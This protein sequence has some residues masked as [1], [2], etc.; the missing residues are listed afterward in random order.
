[1]F[2]MARKQAQELARQYLSGHCTLIAWWTLRHAG[3]FEAIVK[4]Q[5]ENGEG[6]DPLVHATRTSMSPDVLRAL[7]DYLASVGLITMKKDGAH[8]SSEG[9]ALLEHE[10]AVLEL[11]RAYQLVLDMA[12]HLLA[13]LKTYAPAG[14]N[15]GAGAGVS[16]VRKSE[17]LA[18]SQAKRYAGEVYPAVGELVAKYKLAHLLDI[19]CGTGELLVHVATAHKRVVGVGI[20]S[21]GISV[22]KANAA[23]TAADL[24]KRLIAVTASPFDVC[25]DTQHTFDRIGVSRQL[26]KAINGILATNLFSE[27][28]ARP[29]EIART[30]TAVQKNF[31]TAT[32]ILIEPTASA[33]FDRN[34]YAPELTLV[35]SLARAVPWPVEQWRTALAQARY[36]LV[37]E[38]PLTTDGLTIFTCKPQT[39]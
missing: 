24:E 4:S 3:I 34:Y 37:H 15:G 26:W 17:Y 29:D 11:I 8:L 32:L 23:I 19:C 5:S 14:I 21:D 36:K 27:L 13:R 38:T 28:T 25:I 10:D 35:L 33:R 9:R 18:E 39:A 7:L 1:M 16:V 2:S 22:Q 12:E 6:L 31:P 20:G 30:L